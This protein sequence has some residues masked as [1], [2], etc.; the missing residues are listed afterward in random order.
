M[1]TSEIE[2]TNKLRISNT[3]NAVLFF[4]T[5]LPKLTCPKLAEKRFC[6]ETLTKYFQNKK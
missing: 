6:Q 4:P 2:I 5:K 3:I 1:S